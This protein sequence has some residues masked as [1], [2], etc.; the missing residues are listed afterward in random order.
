MLG[1]VKAT[2]LTGGKR[3]T[4]PVRDE[5]RRARGR[6][7]AYERRMETLARQRRLKDAGVIEKA[8]RQAAARGER[9]ECPITPAM[10]L[11][12]LRAL[13]SGCKTDFCCPVLDRIR[14]RLGRV[15]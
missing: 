1:D 6:Q 14:R 12:E 8:L 10:T 2:G 15:S 4:R 3:S 7:R 9:C 11:D 13:G 5:E